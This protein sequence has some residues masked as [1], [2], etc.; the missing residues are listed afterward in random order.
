M[1]GPLTRDVGIKNMKLWILAVFALMLAGCIAI[2]QGSS[3]PKIS[4]QILAEPDKVPLSDTLVALFFEK[5]TEGWGQISKETEFATYTFTDEE[6][7]FEIPARWIISS[8][9]KALLVGSW[10]KAV[11]TLRCIHP[12]Y[13]LA[14]VRPS[15]APL[16]ITLKPGKHLDN[17]DSYIR[18]LLKIHAT[19]VSRGDE[20]KLRRILK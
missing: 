12:N 13:R 9:G 19:P 2:P 16:V 18:E 20:E 14:S 6:G 11:P 4:G 17:E 1:S 10:G 3:T 15:N 7:R 8:Q 5:P